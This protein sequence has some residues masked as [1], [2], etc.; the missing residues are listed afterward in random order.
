M[1]GFAPGRS[2][3]VA[4]Q[5][6]RRRPPRPALVDLTPRQADVLLELLIILAVASGV[7][8]LAIGTSWGRVVTALHAIAGLSLIVLAPAKI[9]GS[10]GTGLRRGRSTRWLSLG[11][12]VLVISAIALGFLHSTGLWFGIGYWTALWTHILVAFAV[13]GL[14]VWHVVSRPS[15]PKLA[16]LGRRGLLRGGAA[17]ALGAAAYGAQEILVRGVG[18]AGGSRRFTGSHEVASFDPGRM[19][20]VSWINDR[21]PQSTSAVDWRL[22]VIGADVRIAQLRRRVRP[23]TA[24]LDCTGGWWSQQSWDAV[25]LSALVGEASARSI[26]VTSATGYSRLFPYSDL[27]NLY[28]ALGYGGEPL[29]RRHGAPVRLVAPARRGLWWVKWVTSVQ[30]DDRPWWLQTPFPLE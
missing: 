2:G 24:T 12:G 7:T 19:P 20:T 9:R 30:L 6:G 28:L 1:R 29:Q 3:V 5:G 8:A 11:F 4:A 14:F 23:L 25:P 13:L 16:D 22:D 26:K 17:V 18:L 10:V 15:R 27:D 21:P